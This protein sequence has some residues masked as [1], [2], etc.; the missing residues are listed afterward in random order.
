MRAA[1]ESMGGQIAPFE[2]DPEGV[3]ARRG[4]AD[5]ALASMT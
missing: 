3:R 5:W 2:F 4:D 1:L